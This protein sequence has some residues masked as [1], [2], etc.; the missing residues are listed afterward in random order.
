MGFLKV[1]RHNSPREVQAARDAENRNKD[2][3]RVERQRQEHSQRK[4][5]MAE[6]TRRR[7]GRGRNGNV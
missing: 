7:A 4:L 5:A 1:T 6:E 2:N 3:E